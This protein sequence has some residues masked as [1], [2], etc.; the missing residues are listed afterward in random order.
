MGGRDWTLENCRRRVRDGTDAD[1]D[2]GAPEPE[3]RVARLRTVYDGDLAG[4]NNVFNC[5]F[6][7]LPSWR[8]LSDL[9]IQLEPWV[10]LRSELGCLRGSKN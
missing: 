1:D 6:M 8:R 9:P 2:V 10:P 3:R 5:I 4:E 7:Y